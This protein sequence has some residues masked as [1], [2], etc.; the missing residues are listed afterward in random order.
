MSTMREAAEEYLAMRRGLGYKLRQEGRMLRQF[1][2]FGEG[3]GLEHLTIEAALEWATSPSEAD[4]SWWAKRL[5]VVRVF[6]R[7]MATMDTRTEVPP[8]D[9]LPRGH[10]RPTTP[11]LYSPEQITALVGEAGA[12]T[13]PLRAATFTAFIGL[14]AVTGLRTGEAMG[15]DR[16]EVDLAEGVLLVQGTKFGKSRLVPLHPSTTDQ[17]RSYARR[18]DELCSRPSTL[19]FFLSG[20]GT[21]L[22]HTNASKTFNRLL[23]ATGICTL[24]GAAKPRLYDLRHSFAVATLV[25]W[26]SQDADVTHLLPALSTYMGHISPATTYWYLHACPQLI[27]AAATRL[28]EVWKESA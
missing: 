3:H 14:M 26:Y 15:L 6:A 5:T 13:S 1:V 19:A 24:L 23:R 18:R 12:L 7:H 16:D 9:L 28:E 2:A 17:L 10:Q 21:R 27:A 25:T 4:P 20:A 22:T 8:A 11:Y